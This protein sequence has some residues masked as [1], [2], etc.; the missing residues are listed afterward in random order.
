MQNCS[1]VLIPLF[2]DLAFCILPQTKRLFFVCMKYK[3]LHKYFTTVSHM[4]ELF[5]S[6][7]RSIF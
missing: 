7:E 1:Q 5:F 2:T 3:H 4:F 6:L